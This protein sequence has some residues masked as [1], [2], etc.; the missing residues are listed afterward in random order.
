MTGNDLNDMET[1]RELLYRSSQAIASMGEHPM[2]DEIWTFLR[3]TRPETLRGGVSVVHTETKS[4]Q[5]VIE[6]T[7]D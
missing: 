1:A 7:K 3:R 6:V 2:L 4:G 5:P